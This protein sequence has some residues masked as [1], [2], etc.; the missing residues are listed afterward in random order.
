MN[1]PHTYVRDEAAA[2]GNNDPYRCTCGEILVHPIH[3]HQAVEVQRGRC[4][5]GAPVD[6]ICHITLRSKP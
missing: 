4:S 2:R 1:V 3:P 6:A 5:C